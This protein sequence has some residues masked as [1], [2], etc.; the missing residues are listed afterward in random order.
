MSETV[1]DD[2]EIIEVGQVAMD[3]S[4]RQQGLPMPFLREV[5][6][7]RHTYTSPHATA[8]LVP[9]PLFK[10]VGIRDTQRVDQGCP[11]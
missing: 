4:M 5:F 2:L 6:G 9:V 7:D 1:V 11:F 3:C 10:C 8:I